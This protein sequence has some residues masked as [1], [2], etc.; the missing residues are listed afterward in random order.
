[1]VKQFDDKLF[2]SNVK[3]IDDM[4]CGDINSDGGDSIDIIV[5]KNKH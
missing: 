3:D 2:E 5:D 4:K 1:M